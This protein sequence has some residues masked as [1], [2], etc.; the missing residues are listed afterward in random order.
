[1]PDDIEE[2]YAMTEWIGTVE[3]RLGRLRLIGM[4]DGVVAVAA[5]GVGFMA[6]KGLTNIAKSLGEIGQATNALMQVTFPGA[7]AAD[8]V[9]RP[10]AGTDETLVP[11]PTDVAQPYEAPASE[12]SDAVKEMIAKDPIS[13][14]DLARMDQLKAEGE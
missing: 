5:L 13:P 1:M 9:P 7:V 14:A 3:V 2:D 10:P 12:P 8:V 6:F 4:V 11:P